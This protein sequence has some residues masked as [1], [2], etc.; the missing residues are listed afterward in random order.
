MR[1]LFDQNLSP[2]LVRMGRAQKNRMDES[3]AYRSTAGV[4]ESGATVYPNQMS[5]LTR[6]F[7]AIMDA[8]NMTAPK[9]KFTLM[10]RCFS[11]SIPLPH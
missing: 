6:Y 1:L 4:L 10:F 3:Y 8:K 5:S 11:G 7:I 9:I 2:R